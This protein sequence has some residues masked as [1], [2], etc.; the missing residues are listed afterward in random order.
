MRLS[1]TNKEVIYLNLTDMLH[2]RLCNIARLVNQGIQADFFTDS[3]DDDDFW[4]LLLRLDEENAVVNICGERGNVRLMHSLLYP[5]IILKKDIYNEQYELHTP[6]GVLN[7]EF[8]NM[9]ERLDL[10]NTKEYEYDTFW[11]EV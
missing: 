10:T 9:Y 8:E 1:V 5:K 3:L 11:T 7:Y 6:Y 2:F 4:S